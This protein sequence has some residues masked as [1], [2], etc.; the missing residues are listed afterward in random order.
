MSVDLLTLL[1][2]GC[3]YA[4]GGMAW[5]GIYDLLCARESRPEALLGVKRFFVAAIWPLLL[6]V[7][8]VLCGWHR[9]GRGWGRR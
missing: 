5:L 2:W 4:L 8:L 3:L 7:F 6:V 1:G 9:A